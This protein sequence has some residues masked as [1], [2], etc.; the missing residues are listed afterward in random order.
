VLNDTGRLEICCKIRNIDRL[1]L[2]W[3]YR[4][5]PGSTRSLDC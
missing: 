4:L 1:I 3:S 5:F 2:V